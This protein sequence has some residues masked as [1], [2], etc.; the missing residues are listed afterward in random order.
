MACG[1]NL[2]VQDEV[3]LVHEDGSH[4]Y[5]EGVYLAYVLAYDGVGAARDPAVVPRDAIDEVSVVWLILRED[6]LDERILHIGEGLPAF[7]LEVVL[8]FLHG[9]DDR[10]E[11][12]GLWVVVPP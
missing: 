6:I 2:E 12:I 11:E 3:D 4:W 1:G 9:Y 10:T 8:F 7:L 5:L